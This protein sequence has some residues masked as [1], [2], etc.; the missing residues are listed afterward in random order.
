MCDYIIEN[1]HLIREGSL[2]WYIYHLAKS[3]FAKIPWRRQ[4]SDEIAEL[5]EFH[6]KDGMPLTQA[7]QLVASYVRKSNETVKQAHVRYRRSTKRD[8]LR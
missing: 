6:I 3:L 7:R 5:V 8:K 4:S 2:D 1:P